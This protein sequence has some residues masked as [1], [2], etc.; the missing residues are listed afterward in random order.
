MNAD[1]VGRSP[2]IA[3]GVTAATVVVCG[4]EHWCAFLYRRREACQA[5]ARPLA[6]EK[7]AE[8]LKLDPYR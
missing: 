7:Q 1:P 4:D 5:S 6:E 8:Q 2:T 3:E